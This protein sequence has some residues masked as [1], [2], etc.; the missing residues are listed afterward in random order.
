MTGHTTTNTCLNTLFQLHGTR[1][2]Y[3]YVPVVASA[4]AVALE[5]PPLPKRL[6]QA[7]IVLESSSSSSSSLLST[8]SSVTVEASPDSSPL[9][10]KSEKEAQP[11]ADSALSFS[12]P[13]S[14]RGSTSVES[15]WSQFEPSFQVNMLFNEYLNIAG[16]S[17]NKIYTHGRAVLSLC[18]HNTTLRMPIG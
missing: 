4:C 8:D 16:L 6:S 14:R 9:S 13:P 11:S 7:A 18:T 3:F 15:F 1:K 2:D 10:S 17:L 12:L 5:K